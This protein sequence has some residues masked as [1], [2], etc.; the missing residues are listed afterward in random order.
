[1]F[2]Y[3]FYCKSGEKQKKW[4]LNWNGH[5]IFERNVQSVKVTKVT[6]TA[7]PFISF[8]AKVVQSYK[9]KKR[10]K[11]KNPFSRAIIF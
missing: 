9:N 5:Q 1:M 4:P 2:L 8:V 3:K 6:K 10:E 7:V 11:G